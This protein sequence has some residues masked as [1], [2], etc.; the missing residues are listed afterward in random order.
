MFPREVGKI[1]ENNYNVQLNVSL[2]ERKMVLLLA[3]Y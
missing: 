1:N 3:L 2:I